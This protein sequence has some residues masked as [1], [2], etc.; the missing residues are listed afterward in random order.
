MNQTFVDHRSGQPIGARLIWCAL[1]SKPVQTVW[2]TL[3][4]ESL[5]AHCHGA[6]ENIRGTELRRPGRIWVF[7]AAAD[8]RDEQIRIAACPTLEM[9]ALTLAGDE[10]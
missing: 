3:I 6:N 5:T 2:S 1:C 4:D 10:P 7:Q 8:E 9:I